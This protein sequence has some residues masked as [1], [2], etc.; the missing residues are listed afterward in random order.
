M[1][2]KQS[3]KTYGYLTVFELSIALLH[4]HQGVLVDLEVVAGVGRF[5]LELEAEE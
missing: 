2:C 4:G 1:K 3:C 5:H